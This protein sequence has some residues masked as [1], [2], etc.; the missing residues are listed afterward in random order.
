MIGRKILTGKGYALVS[1]GF[2]IC[3]AFLLN[4][5]IIDRTGSPS[6]IETHL[7]LYFYTTAILFFLLL[8][9]SA[10]FHNAVTGTG[11]LWGL[12]VGLLFADESKFITRLEH[13]Y[14][15]DLFMVEHLGDMTDMYDARAGME[16]VK[17]IALIVAA[18][19]AVGVALGFLRRKIGRK[20]RAE[21]VVVAE[22]ISNGLRVEPAMTEN[23]PQ[24]EVVPDGLRVE[25][26]MTENA[27]AKLFRGKVFWMIKRL[28]NRV[29]QSRLFQNRLV[30]NRVFRIVM[31]RV[32]LILACFVV[33][34]GLT[35]P[36]RGTTYLMPKGFEYVAWDQT[37][38]YRNNGFVMA[39]F[40]NLRM[41]RMEK[42]DGYSE[43]AIGA[44]VEKYAKE[45][46]KRNEDRAD[47]DAEQIDIVYI[48]NESFSDPSDFAAY[49]PY[50]GGDV[51]PRLH[52]IEQGGQASVG[53]VFSARY[54]GGTA[55]IEFEA[56]TGLSMYF[57]RSSTPFHGSL[58]AKESFPSVA[59]LLSG[60]YGYD[61]VGL[62]PFQPG[63]YKRATVYPALGFREFHGLNDFTYTAHD[64]TARYVS[65]ESAYKELLKYL[66]R[67][68]ASNR[69]I[70]LVTMQNHMPYGSLYRDHKF[71]SEFSGTETENMKIEDYLESLNSADAALGEFI[72]G[73]AERDRKTIVVFWGDHLPGVYDDLEK[74]DVK[75]GLQYNT[76]FFIYANYDLAQAEL[77]MISPNYISTTVLDKLNMKKPAFYYLLDE[78]KETTP[79]LTLPY[80]GKDEP[81]ETDALRAYQL[82]E[83]DM[84]KGGA[85]AEKL[86]FFEIQ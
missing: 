57:L 78:L 58:S 25:P 14:P 19:I 30:K 46:E 22:D 85:Y 1:I 66:N 4:W 50:S 65:D 26:A 79:I 77:G 39:F 52:E 48:M 6:F 20:A 76:P 45:A 72:D 31:R 33:L 47:P 62:H 43:K 61:S 63:M 17:I 55:D 2:L 54:G 29:R 73:I 68:D 24:A 69:L 38:N 49:Y 59:G 13:L 27:V 56:Y 12:V 82:I 10:L 67:G 44:I 34:V 7:T 35:A 86:G 71:T 42:P 3:M 18:S 80:F 84:L 41:S 74:T 53:N 83:Y 8:L 11:I 36:A 15:S 21:A 37:A 9:F 81:E 16:Q 5:Y 51:T 32:V 40:S 64:R 70:T 60:R 75:E 23:A 28:I